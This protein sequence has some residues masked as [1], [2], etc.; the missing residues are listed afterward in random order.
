MPRSGFLLEDVAHHFHL[1][2]QNLLDL[3]IS[4]A[5][6]VDDHATRVLVVLLDPAVRAKRLGL[7][8]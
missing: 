6:T 1:V 2:L 8:R 3:P 5:I 7:I 4:H